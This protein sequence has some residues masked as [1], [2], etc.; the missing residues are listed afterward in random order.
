MGLKVSQGLV[1]WMENQVV[2]GQPDSL[3]VLAELER[4]VSADKMGL[5]DVT[6]PKD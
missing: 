5:Q 3:E 4:P 6:D 1:A 2:R